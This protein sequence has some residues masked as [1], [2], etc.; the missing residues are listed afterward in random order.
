MEKIKHTR[1][2]RKICD[3]ESKRPRRNG[4]CNS[5]YVKVEVEIT[6]GDT[7]WSYET[8]MKYE[9]YS[10]RIYLQNRGDKGDIIKEDVEELLMR[11]FEW[12]EERYE[13]GRIWE[14]EII[15]R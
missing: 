5:A 4:R 6:L 9:E 14:A 7:S 8:I 10:F 2:L 3:I 15:K 11:A 12:G 13:E 1:I